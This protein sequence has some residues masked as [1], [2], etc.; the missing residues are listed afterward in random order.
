VV[1]TPGVVV[2]PVPG[3][4]VEEGRRCPAGTHWGPDLHRC[5]R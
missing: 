4:V 2:A 1:V 5:V 3:V